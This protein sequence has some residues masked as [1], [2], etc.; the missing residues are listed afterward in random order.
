MSEHLNSEVIALDE[1]PGLSPAAYAGF[2]SMAVADW[3][4]EPIYVT[5]LRP[6]D[7]PSLVAHPRIS[8]LATAQALFGFQVDTTKGWAACPEG[9]ACWKL[10]GIQLR[11]GIAAI[12]PLVIGPL[13]MPNAN[14]LVY[15]NWPGADSQPVAATPPYYSNYVG[16]WTNGDGVVGFGY[17]GGGVVAPGGG[18][19]AVWPSNGPTAPVVLEP[20]YADCLQKVGWLGGTDH[21]TPSPVF[22]Y[23]TKPAATPTP[24]P[25]GDGCLPKFLRA[26]LAAVET[27]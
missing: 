14:I 15:E 6:S 18:P 26:I 3:A 10:I 7:E 1:I 25:A 9:Q 23:V 4:N 20:Q 16:G 8:D 27:K 13:G 24:T 2:A 17:G 21:F 22:A 11:T 5:D 19:F 12:I